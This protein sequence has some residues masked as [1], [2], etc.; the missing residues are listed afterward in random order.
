MMDAETVQLLE[1]LPDDLRERGWQLSRADSG[2]E[3]RTMPTP[4]YRAVFVRPF[5]DHLD[6]PGTSWPV[7]DKRTRHRIVRIST[8]QDRSPT[9]EA[10]RLD[11]IRRMREADARYRRR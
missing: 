11:A 5:V 10:A 8:Y 6:T 1:E 2:V 4:W 7:Y 3:G 9:W